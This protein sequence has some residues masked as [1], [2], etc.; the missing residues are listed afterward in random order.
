MLNCPIE[1]FLPISVTNK[2][3]QIDLKKDIL[4]ISK[5]ILFNITKENL[6]KM[7]VD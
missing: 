4:L 3:I 7:R 2:I 1:I 5:T 6:I